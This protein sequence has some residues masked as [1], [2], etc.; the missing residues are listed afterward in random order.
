MIREPPPAFSAARSE[1]RRAVYA[2]MSR[3]RSPIATTCAFIR[4]TWPRRHDPQP[5]KDTI[6][7]LISDRKCVSCEGRPF[8]LSR[9]DFTG[10]RRILDFEYIPITEVFACAHKKIVLW[11]STRI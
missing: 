2:G 5:S 3:R 10:V 4:I 9:L 1:E 11:H 7:A 6:A 8:S